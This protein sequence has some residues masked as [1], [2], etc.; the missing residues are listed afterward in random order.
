MYLLSSYDIPVIRA[1]YAAV[2]REI[3]LG[4]KTWADDFQYVE[5]V[6][7]AKFKPKLKPSFSTSTSENKN[8]VSSLQEDGSESIWFC[9]KFQR[10]K[11]PHKSA[12]SVVL[13]GK[14]RLAKHICASCWQLDR[15]QLN[16]PECSSACPHTSA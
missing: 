1:V 15:K 16:H 5:S 14:M 4:R 10:N 8:K 9:S 2:L 7:L 6:V 12:H 11:C 3:E 13:K